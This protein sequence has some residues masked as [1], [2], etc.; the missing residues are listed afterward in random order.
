MVEKKNKTKSNRRVRACG[1]KKEQ[2]KSR[3]GGFVPGRKKEQKK[4]EQEGSRLW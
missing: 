3:T 1:R 4:V 2:N